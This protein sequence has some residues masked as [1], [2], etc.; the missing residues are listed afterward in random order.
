[1]NHNEQKVSAMKIEI[2]NRFTN[3]CLWTGEV[4]EQGSAPKNLGAAVKAALASGADLFRANLSGANLS[5][6][7]LFGANLSG[8]NLSGANLSGADLFGADLSG[9]DLSGANLSGADLSGANLS[10]KKLK[11]LRAFSGLYQYPIWAYI[12]EDGTPCVRMGC[13]YKTMPEWDAVTIRESN[14]S[15]FPNDGSAKSEQR[16]RAFEFARG[17]AL[18]MASAFAPVAVADPTP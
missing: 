6:A 14:T 13:L 8:A 7:D 12:L 4:E 15:E 5:G 3:T 9:A 16:A 10:G 17:E 18:L 2:K 11:A 1:M